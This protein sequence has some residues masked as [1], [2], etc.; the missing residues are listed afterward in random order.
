M[1]V[2]FINK[3]TGTVMWV[4]DK[5]ADE[6][7]KLGYKT[8]EQKEIVRPGNKKEEVKNDD[9]ISAAGSTKTQRKSKNVKTD[10][11][12]KTARKR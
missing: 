9:G 5:R 12:K 11:E 1:A 10:S 8:A 7:R 4:D 2:K 3:I 6:Y